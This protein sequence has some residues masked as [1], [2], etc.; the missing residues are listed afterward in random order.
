[1][2]AGNGAEP[3]VPDVDEQRE[4]DVHLGNLQGQTPAEKLDS[5][6][7][8]YLDRLAATGMT[9]AGLQI[10][11]N[12][13]DKTWI[14][15]NLSDAEVHEIKWWMEVMYIKIKSRFPPKDS[16]IQGP[17]RAYYYADRDELLWA[18]TDKQ[19]IIISQM[20]K[21][22]AVYVTRSKQGFQQEQL[23]KS[24]DV[25]EVRNPDEDAQDSILA[26]IRS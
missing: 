2:S 24:I 3:A 1:M 26:G 12:M 22:I 18:L 21:G 20:L 5:A 10:L 15:G 23:V 17:L 8:Q 9:D 13:V 7:A 14:L 19:K 4:W 16:N 11:D 6:K 25:S